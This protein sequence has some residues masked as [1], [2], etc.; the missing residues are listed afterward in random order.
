MQVIHFTQAAADPLESSDERRNRTALLARPHVGTLRLLGMQIFRTRAATDPLQGFGASATSFLPLADG[1]GDTHI[2]CLHL[3]MGSKIEAP[4][5]THASALLCVHG[6]ITVATESPKTQ[7]NVH[8]GMGAVLEK[9]EAYSLQSEEGAILLIVEAQELT[10]HARATSTPK[11]IAG[12]TWPSDRVV[13]LHRQA[14][15]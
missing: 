12:A 5:V 15:A 10:P 8:A 6:R 3:E 9:D 7:I 11:R 4:S 13:R 1:Q 14:Q 2:S